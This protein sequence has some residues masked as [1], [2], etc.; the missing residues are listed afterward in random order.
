MGQVSIVIVGRQ[1][2]KYLTAENHGSIQVL[3]KENAVKTECLDSTRY[4]V[5]NQLDTLEW[6]VKTVHK[7]C[8][9]ERLAFLL[10]TSPELEDATLEEPLS[11]LRTLHMRRLASMTTLVV[12]D[13]I[14]EAQMDIDQLFAELQ[15]TSGDFERQLLVNNALRSGVNLD[16]IREMLDYLDACGSQCHCTREDVGSKTVPV[17]KRRKWGWAS[18]F[19]H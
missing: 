4:S 9:V 19:T 7:D 1:S 17:R 6:T 12:T 3:L 10:K 2:V 15:R 16:Q 14:D 5:R 18:F 8:K 11:L 13:P